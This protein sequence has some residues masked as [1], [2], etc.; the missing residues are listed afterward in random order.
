MYSISNSMHALNNRVFVFITVV[1]KNITVYFDE[2]ILT[3]FIR[4]GEYYVA[5]MF[6]CT[7]DISEVT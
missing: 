5:F 6:S 2:Q 4:I 3:Y 7:L 1:V